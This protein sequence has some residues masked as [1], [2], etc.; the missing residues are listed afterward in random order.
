VGRSQTPMNRR[1]SQLPV[2]HLSPGISPRENLGKGDCDSHIGG[3]GVEDGSDTISR[4]VLLDL[5]SSSMPRVARMKG[6]GGALPGNQMS[7][8]SGLSRSPGGHL[9]P[10]IS[11]LRNP[12][13][14][15]GCSH[16]SGN[17]V[18]DGSDTISRR[19][20]LDLRSSSMPRGARISSGG[21]SPANLPWDFRGVCRGPRCRIRHRHRGR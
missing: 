3:N 6:R 1:I 9:S 21:P 7:V 13:K 12:R 15:N 20:L 5:R 10:G 4:R 17:G 11:L 8:G 18:E 14:G 2:G 19:V 16:I